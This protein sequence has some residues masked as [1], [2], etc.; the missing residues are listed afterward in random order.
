LREKGQNV[1]TNITRS[2]F[3]FSDDLTGEQVG[4]DSD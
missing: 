2:A 3:E 1:T 4:G